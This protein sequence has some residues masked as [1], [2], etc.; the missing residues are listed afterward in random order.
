MCD[1]CVPPIRVLLLVLVLLL[2]PMRLVFFEPLAVDTLLWLLLVPPE[3]S[4]CE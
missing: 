4:E 2:V 3:A 1:G